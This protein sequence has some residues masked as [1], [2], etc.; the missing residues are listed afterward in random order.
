MERASSGPIW[1]SK[2]REWLFLKQVET[3]PSAGQG[4]EK[5]TNQTSNQWAVMDSPTPLTPGA[6]QHNSLG[7][8]DAGERFPP[9]SVPAQ[10]EWSKHDWSKGQRVSRLRPLCGSLIPG[11]SFPPLPWGL[12]TG[13]AWPFPKCRCHYHCLLPS[14]LWGQTLVLSFLL[15]L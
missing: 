1:E 13:P 11:L 2:S 14:F 10:G 3:D 4:S 15:S 5:Q 9:A 7:L 6:A 12:P 8:S